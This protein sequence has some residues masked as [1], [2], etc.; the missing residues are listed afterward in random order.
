VSVPPTHEDD[1]GLTALAALVDKYDRMCALRARLGRGA[2][3]R[4]DREQLRGLARDFPGALRELETIDTAELAR[5]A[6]VARAA[7]ASSRPSDEAPDWLR[8]MAGYHELM[9]RALALRA[10]RGDPLD[11]LAE[12]VRAPRHGRLNVIVFEALARRFGTPATVIWDALFP[13]RGS[14]PRPYRG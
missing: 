10:G 13:R 7:V 11:E 12:A 3:A 6:A 1:A 8:W 4:D 9:R 5:R 2:P 14:A